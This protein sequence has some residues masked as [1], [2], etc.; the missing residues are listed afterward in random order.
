MF[1]HKY[2]RKIGLLVQTKVIGTKKSTLAG[3][4]VIYHKQ[5]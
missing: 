4:Y 1:K 5:C 3:S 2:V